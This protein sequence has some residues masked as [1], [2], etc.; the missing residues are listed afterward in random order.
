MRR[1]LIERSVSRTTSRGPPA[2]SSARLFPALVGNGLY[3]GSRGYWIDIGTAGRYLG[4]PRP[5]A[6]A[7]H[8]AAAR[9]ETDSLIYDPRSRL[10]A[11]IG[12]L[13]VVGPHCSVGDRARSS[14]PCCSRACSWVGKAK[15]V[16]SVVDSA[17]ASARGANRTRR[18][19]RRGAEVAAG[20]VVGR[21]ERIAPAGGSGVSLA[22]ARRDAAVAIPRHAGRVLAQRTRSATRCGQRRRRSPAALHAGRPGRLRMGGSRIGGDLGRAAIGGRAGRPLRVV[23]GYDLVPWMAGDALVLCS[24]YSGNN[25]ETLACFQPPASSAPPAWSSRPAASWRKLARR[26]RRAGDRRAVGHAAACAVVT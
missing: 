20:A 13:S 2:R 14:A 7:F 8:D 18:H 19:R 25:E 16:E 12:P 15:I 4:R 6:G 3:G 23:R 5:A 26:G 21:G 24:S 10:G 17:R 11:R 1:L 22:L 9:D